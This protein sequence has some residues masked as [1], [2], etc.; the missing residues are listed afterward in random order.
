MK[1]II[2]LVLIIITMNYLWCE[3]V[4]LNK[5]M[6]IRN[7]TSSNEIIIR[8]PENVE[9]DDITG[10]IIKISPIGDIFIHCR[11]KR[12]MYK[13]DIDN[14]RLIT[15]LNT[16]FLPQENFAIFTDALQKSFLFWGFNGRAYLVDSNNNLKFS[17]D[18]LYNWKI[19][20]NNDSAYYDEDSDILFLLDNE[21]NSSIKNPKLDDNQNQK[22]YKNPDETK[23]LI[24]KGNYG[25]NVSFDSKNR[26][27]INGKRYG[28]GKSYETD[29]CIISFVS[30]SG[31][32][33]VNVYDGKNRKRL[34][35]NLQSNEEIESYTFHP[36]GDWYILTINWST[37]I[38]TLWKIE[39]TWDPEWREQW[40]KEHPSANK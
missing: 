39:N 12:E 26:L 8:N 19:D 7:G 3:D 17:I 10:N 40:Y 11:D 25:K 6:T 5:I 27:L 23:L 30:N 37:N 31:Y 16:R 15:V 14:N 29:N 36:N 20:V 35:F 24:Q 9:E 21:K 32:N 22:N 28:W 1:K 38:H 13:L 4:Q 34:N 18:M 33:Y 2:N